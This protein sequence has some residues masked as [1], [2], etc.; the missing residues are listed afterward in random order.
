[1]PERTY[2]HPRTL[3]D[4]PGQPPASVDLQG[5]TVPVD[6]SGDTATFTTTDGS[7]VEAFA[8]AYGVTAEDLVVDD[9]G[10]DGESGTCDVVKS[11]GEV[12]GRDLPCPYHSEGD[13]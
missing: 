2:R 12:C 7:A 5:E 1:M 13:D 9:A 4:V 8:R 6:R 10:D 3:A 11:D